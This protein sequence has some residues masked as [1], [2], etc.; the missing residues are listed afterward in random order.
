MEENKEQAEKC[1]D[2]AKTYLKNGD[3]TKAI[4]FFEKSKRL[5]PLPG[6]DGLITRCKSLQSQPS[7]SSG[8]RRPS[9]AAQEATNN[10]KAQENGTA[11]VRGS[12]PEQR[13]L[14]SEVVRNSK[15]QEA[16]YKVLGVAKSASDAEIKKAYRKL[17]LKVHPDK[18][19]APGSDE[20]FKAVGLAY[21]TLSDERKRQI[22]DSTGDVDPDNTGGSSDPFAGFRRG[23]GGGGGRHGEVD[24]EDIFRM[25]FNGGMGGGMGGG[26]GGPGFRVYS[27]GTGFGGMPNRRHTERGRRQQ[28]AG[29]GQGL[30]QLLPIIFFIL[31]SFVSFPEE[32]ATSSSQYFSLT[33]KHPYTNP[34]ETKHRGVVKDIP[35][36][37]SDKFMRT[38][39][40]DP[41]KVSQVERLVEKS[42]DQFLQNECRAQRKHQRQLQ[43]RAASF[44]GDQRKRASMQADADAFELSRCQEHKDLFMNKGRR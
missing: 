40:R 23:G 24:P 27:S 1:R 14:V 9:A 3:Y 32:T 29:G 30:L 43:Q 35:Y 18:N 15:K 12:T 33:H 44:R 5:Y 6:L 41:Y 36:F 16:H 4:K 13:R 8:P 10:R 20:A 26:F 34:M 2:L 22:Y 19:P 11:D 42:Y 25:F 37:V 39:I 28:E 7:P 17:S 31:M 38:T 21:A